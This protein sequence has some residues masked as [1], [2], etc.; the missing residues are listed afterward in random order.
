[1]KNKYII[2]IA[3]VVI[4]VLSLVAFLPGAI[5]AKGGEKGNGAPTGPDYKKVYSLNIIGVPNDKNA[6]VDD[7]N[8]NGHRIFVPLYG[9]TKIWLEEAPI[10]DNTFRV[11][12]YDGTDAGGAELQMPNP[13]EDDPADENDVYIYSIYV[14]ALGKPKGKAIITPGFYD[15][16][17]A[18]YSLTNVTV[19]RLNGKDNQARFSDKTVAL[20]Q[21]D[22]DWDKDGSVDETIRLFD[23]RYEDYF[24]EYDNNGLKVLQMRFYLLPG[25]S[26]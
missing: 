1:M 12:D 9:K 2:G 24:W 15:G 22:V 19:E 25:K 7:T 21:I 3:L 18:W 10:E 5:A 23:K 4:M 8:S 13:F 6:N 26:L 16:S 11:L 17:T 14:R 20:T